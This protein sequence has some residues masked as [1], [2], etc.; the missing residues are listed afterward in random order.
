M[1]GKSKK[2][3]DYLGLGMEQLRNLGLSGCAQE[4]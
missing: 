4:T 1:G 2:G 3:N